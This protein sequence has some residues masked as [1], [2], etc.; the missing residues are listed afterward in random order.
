[1]NCD[2][3]FSRSSLMYIIFMSLALDRIRN[4]FDAQTYGLQK[5]HDKITNNKPQQIAQ[6]RINT[7]FTGMHL[8]K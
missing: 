1:M 2:L 7:I 6:K 3:L 8:N 4:E 5:E